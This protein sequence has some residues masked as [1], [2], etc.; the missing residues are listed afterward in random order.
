[1]CVDRHTLLTIHLTCRRFYASLSSLS[2]VAARTWVSCVTLSCHCSRA[3]KCLNASS[4]CSLLVNL[5]LLTGEMLHIFVVFYINVDHS[6][7]IL[8]S[9]WHDLAPGCHIDLPVAAAKFATLWLSG[10]WFG[11]SCWRSVLRLS[12]RL[13]QN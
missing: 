11:S 1:M 13:C 4:F 2:R 5:L 8:D 3:I 7:S 9:R 6:S 10:H 12:S